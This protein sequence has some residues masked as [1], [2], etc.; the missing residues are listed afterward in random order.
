MEWIS[1]LDTLPE[2]E[3]K[4]LVLIA[5]KIFIANAKVMGSCYYLSASDEIVFDLPKFTKTIDGITI[6][7]DG[8]R[9]IMPSHFK[10]P[11]HWMYIPAISNKEAQ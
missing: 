11:S 10:E 7:S 3:S 2:K 1:V 4:I 8:N 6:R 5:E 9:W